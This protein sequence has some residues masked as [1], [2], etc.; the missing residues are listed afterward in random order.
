MTGTT[1]SAFDDAGELIVTEPIYV[2]TASLEGSMD[3]VAVPGVAGPEALT[4]SQVPP[5]AEAEKAA[6]ELEPSGVTLVREMGMGAGAG[7]PSP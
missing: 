4:E 7:S 3:K 5:L 1:W 2:P 6:V